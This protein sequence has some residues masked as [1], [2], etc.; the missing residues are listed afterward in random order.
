MPGLPTLRESGYSFPDLSDVVRS[1]APSPRLPIVARLN[2]VVAKV[3][4]MPAVRTKLLRTSY[5]PAP[6]TAQQ[7]AGFIADDIAA[8]TSLGKEAHIEPLD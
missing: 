5:A 1:W 7:Y 4:D 3:L 2:G 6:M 8:M